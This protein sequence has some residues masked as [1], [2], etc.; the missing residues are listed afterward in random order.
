MSDS[1]GSLVDKLS[2]TNMKIWHVQ[3]FIYRVSKMTADDFAKL[4]PAEV[5]G[6]IQKL[7]WLNLDRNRLMTE[8]DE[9]LHAAVTSGK[10]Q[11]ERRVKIT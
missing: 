4:P 7:A 11:V 1:L 5:H 10:T 2:V 6:E 3:D 9:S 8:I